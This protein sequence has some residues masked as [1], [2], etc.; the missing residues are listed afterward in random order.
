M[1][2]WV[3]YEPDEY[4]NDVTIIINEDYILNDYYNY[5]CRKM[6]G[7]LTEEAYNSLSEVDKKEMCIEDFVSLHWAREIKGA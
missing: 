5:W 7:R 3:Y 4:N 6:K 1:R 2:R